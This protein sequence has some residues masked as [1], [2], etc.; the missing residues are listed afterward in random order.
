MPRSL[1][2]DDIRQEVVD[3][4]DR[5]ASRPGVERIWRDPLVVTARTDYR[6]EALRRWVASDH[7]LPEDLLDGARSVVVFF[8]PFVARLADE[9]DPGKRP[10]RSW[11]LAYES[12]NELIRLVGE[13]LEVLL[14]R[15]G[16]RS[17]TTPPTH[18]FDHER[19][20]SRW[21]HKHLAYLSGLGRFGVNAQLITPSGC[22]GRLG[23]LVTDA[24][25]GDDPLVT[26]RE[27][28]LHRLGAG[29][30]ECV[31]RCPVSA[32]GP[33]GIDRHRCWKRL[34]SNLRRTDSLAGLDAETRVCGKCQVLLPCSLEA[35]AGRSGGDGGCVGG[36]SRQ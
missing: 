3:V 21:S 28:C 4:V 18:N 20:I 11:G 8:L 23:S 19:L 29:C 33:D 9:N 7:L 32:V 15:H 35:P 16:C 25:L 14:G 17:A 13:A 24:D 30:L 27:L 2:P 12:T 26:N 34:Q 36:R 1:E 31:E 5:H 6:F 10:S 22:A